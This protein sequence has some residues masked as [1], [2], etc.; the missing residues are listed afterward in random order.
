MRILRATFFAAATLAALAAGV[1]TLGAQA[2]FTTVPSSFSRLA[3]TPPR[4][5]PAPAVLPAAPMTMQPAPMPMQTQ[6]APMQAPMSSPMPAA[7]PAPIP[8]VPAPASMSPAAMPSAPMRADFAPPADAAPVSP[9]LGARALGTE[10]DHVLRHL[11]NNIQGFRLAGEIASTEWPVFLTSA[12]T[13]QKLRFQAGYLTAVSVM[14]EASYLTLSINDTVVGRVNLRAT[15][16]VRTV[17][18]DVPFGLM[19]PGFNSIRLSAEQRHR[20]DCSLQATYE[21]WTQI[22][23]AQT[24]LIIPRAAGGVT[25]LAELASLSPDA[26]GA[27]PIRAV[28]PGR[29]SLSNVERI[30]R[31]AQMI[32]LVGRFEQ[33]VV[34]IGPLADGQYGLNLVIGT[35]QEI[36]GLPDLPR[37]GVTPGPRI[38]VL[39]PAPGRRTTV[40]VTGITDAEV[41]QALAQFDPGSALVGTTAG[42]RA[43]AAFPGYRM[44]GGQRVSLKDLGV[45]SEEFGGR[46]FRAAFNVIMPPD[47]YPADYAKAVLHLAGGYAPGLTTEAQMVISV[48]GRNAV[49]RKLPKSKGDVFTQAP[50]P[51]P[52]SALRPGLNRVE[53]EAQVPTAGDVA[54]DPLASIGGSN[55]FLFLDTTEIEVPRIARIA[56]MPD[57]AVT[58]TGGFPYA[59]A[60]ARPNLIVP[61]PDRE[62]IG[63]AATL[64]AQMAIAAGQPIDFALSATMPEG[65]SGAKLIVA[66]ARGLDPGFFA[67]AGVSPEDVTSA[68]AAR[69]DE[70]EETSRDEVLSRF[71]QVA[72]DRL[73]MQRNFPASCRMAKPVGGFAHADKTAWRRTDMMPVATVPTGPVSGK[74]FDD[75][76]TKLNAR[77]GVVNSVSGYYEQARFW[78]DTHWFRATRSVISLFVSTTHSGKIPPRASLF[79][80]QNILGDTRDD[81]V[82]LISAPNATALAASVAC[83]VDPRVWQTV[84]GR[85]S[86]LDATEGSVTGVP[87]DDPRLIVTEPLTLGNTRLIAAGWLSLNNHVYVG[88]ALAAAMLLALSTTLFVQGVG[89]R[90]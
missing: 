28:V 69:F 75:W 87:A 61:S 78:V 37:F 86:F 90:N 59:G 1:T 41:S 48:N 53:I 80:A 19:Q 76:T 84:S 58:M 2:I 20:V 33:P 6:T 88:L 66:P 65:A 45:I 72:R 31:V 21:L 15:R 81:V 26:Q 77:T 18:F 23:P 63:A 85:L 83:L 34:D 13:K 8:F 71:E 22:D 40:V 60:K 57:L 89:R 30:I 7:A 43:A 82:T 54:C 9:L 46:L 44:D 24:G 10:E 51:L 79:V 42:T 47:F 74:L 39:P 17:S 3:P 52:L 16:A 32:S 73:I 38:A 35:A 55:R 56:R 67:L 14:P 11:T 4:A 68:W 12:Q 29:T 27:L 64:A 25:S 62:S 70:R 49:S 50:V 36:A 5:E